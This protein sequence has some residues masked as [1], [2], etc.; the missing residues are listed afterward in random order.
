MDDRGVHVS[1]AG[2]EAA[3]SS[4]I[5]EDEGDPRREPLS[6]VG[7][8]ARYLPLVGRAERIRRLRECLES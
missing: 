1:Y 8:A 5:F 6:P 4:V 2:Y 7:H 3:R